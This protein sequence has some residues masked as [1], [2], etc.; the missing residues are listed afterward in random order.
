MPRTLSIVQIGRG[1][2]GS[3]LV[4]QVDAARAAV[5]EEWGVD[6]RQA[7][8][9]GRDDGPDPGAILERAARTTP[10]PRLFVDATAAEGMAPVHR[11][12][13]LAGFHV[14]TCNKKPLAG[15]LADYDAIQSAARTAGRFYLF[16]VTVGAGLPVIATLRDLRDTGDRVATIEGCF[17]GT[18][19]FL[20]TAL[21]A[22]QPFSEALRAARDRG[23]TEPDP[24]DD[25]DG[26]DV[27]RKAI[28]LAR[29]AGL[30]VEAADVRREPFV[31]VDRGEEREGFLRRAGDHDFALRERVRAA[32]SRGLRLRYVA[33]VAPGEGC[34]AGLTEVPDDSPLGRLAGPEN[35]FVFTTGRYH[36]HPLVVSG[37]GAGPEVTAAGAFADLM[38]VVRAV[39]RG[40][41]GAPEA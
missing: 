18:L 38:T 35:V 31:P 15:P 36:H 16:E 39:A 3:R 33:R 41:N 14:V 4:A 22:D 1:Q 25:L 30:P 24:R 13:L 2:V 9:A 19:N 7:M 20:C 40:G 21:D 23:F 32:A 12:A 11:Q 26:Q 27:A 34:R 28:I 29:A 8:V 5:I 6:L 17:S 37:P 10:P